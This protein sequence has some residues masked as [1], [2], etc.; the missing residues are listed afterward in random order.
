MKKIVHSKI[1]NMQ[2]AE[3]RKGEFPF[4]TDYNSLK[5]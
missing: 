4:H 5:N 3:N 1:N 2:V